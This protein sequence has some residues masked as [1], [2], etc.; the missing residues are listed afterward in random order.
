M[1]RGMHKEIKSFQRGNDDV[2]LDLDSFTTNRPLTT[3]VLMFEQK[4]GPKSRIRTFLCTCD[5]GSLQIILDVY[6]GIFDPSITIEERYNLSLLQAATC[7]LR[8][9]FDGTIS[10]TKLVEWLFSGTE[11]FQHVIENSQ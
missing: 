11:E 2:K 6:G 5:R 1:L 3:H 8:D 9:C 4:E 10:P 7:L